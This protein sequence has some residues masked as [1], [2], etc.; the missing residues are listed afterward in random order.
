MDM[1]NT[2]TGYPNS[3]VN[4]TSSNKN[5]FGSIINSAEEERKR[6]ED[7]RRA[8]EYYIDSMRVVLFTNI[9]EL[10][11]SEAA[12]FWPAYKVY[13][14]QLNKILDHRP[15]ANA[16]L[17]DPFGK[18]KIREYAAFVDIE[19]KSY[20]EEA[21]LREQYSAKFK[22][23]LGEKYHLF[24]RAEYLFIKWIYSNF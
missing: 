4:K 2:Q 24:Y 11:E 16:K 15:D 3:G 9:M 6:I 17:C 10:T 19:V 21:L 20:R 8:I 12:V 13:Q 22:E 5:V 1:G 18:Y 23:I 7:E 14:D